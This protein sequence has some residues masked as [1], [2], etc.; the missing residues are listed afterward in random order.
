MKILRVGD[1][2]CSR[3]STDLIQASYLLPALISERNREAKSSGS[4]PRY[5]FWEETTLTRCPRATIFT[6]SPGWREEITL[7]SP[8]RIRGTVLV[9][10]GSSRNKGRTAGGGEERIGETRDFFNSSRFLVAMELNLSN[11]VTCE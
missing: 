8:G 11:L 5:A 9:T 6:A 1:D 10:P 7:G 2:T 3:V 4:L